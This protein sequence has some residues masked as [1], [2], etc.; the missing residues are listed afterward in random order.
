MQLC[1]RAH[2][3]LGRR[4]I[5]VKIEFG[6][7]RRIAGTKGGA[8][9]DQQRGG[10][11][12]QAGVP[13]FNGRKICQRSDRSERYRVDGG[14]PQNLRNEID[15]MHGLYVPAGGQRDAAQSILELE[16]EKVF[17]IGSVERSDEVDAPVEFI[18]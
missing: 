17:T 4:R 18:A 14:V 9:H 12:Q 1:T 16:G 6:V 2:D 15:S 3:G 13:S 11:L 10:T 5:R 8:T 7:R